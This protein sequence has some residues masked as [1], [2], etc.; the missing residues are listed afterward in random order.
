[1]LEH[2]PPPQVGNQ[3][4]HRIYVRLSVVNRF[5][6]PSCSDFASQQKARE[7]NFSPRGVGGGGGITLPVVRMFISA[8]TYV[9]V[10][11]QTPL[12]QVVKKFEQDEGF[13]RQVKTLRIAIHAA[14]RTWAIPALMGEPGCSG[15]IHGRTPGCTGV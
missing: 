8:C 9:H 15:G 13:D 7:E 14:A 2:G 6:R 1:M 5:L 10:R 12:L 3:G 4:V 11:K